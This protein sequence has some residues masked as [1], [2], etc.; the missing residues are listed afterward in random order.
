MGLKIPLQAPLQAL[1][2]GD[3]VE[4]LI[5]MWCAL[6]SLIRSAAHEHG[7]DSPD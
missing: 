2:C 6:L 1:R 7:F 4:P 3:C 5:Q